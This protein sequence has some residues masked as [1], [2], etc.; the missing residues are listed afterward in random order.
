MDFCS[1]DGDGLIADFQP[2]L[3]RGHVFGQMPDG[4]VSFRFDP[5]DTVFFA[6]RDYGLDFD[7]FLL[8]VSFNGQGN[9]PFASSV[10]PLPVT[11][12]L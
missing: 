9:K 10:M 4:E 11:M 6:S 3:D 2:C 12:R 5:N 8:S 1:I 7:D